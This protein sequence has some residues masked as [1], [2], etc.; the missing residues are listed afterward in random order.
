MPDEQKTHALLEIR[1][2]TVDYPGRPAALSGISFDIHAGEIVGLL[3]ESGGGKTTVG[4][5]VMRVLPADCRVRGSI[6]FRGRDVLGLNER[7][8]QAFRGAEVAMIPQEAGL[9]ANPHL[10]AIHQVEEVVRVHRTL[11]RRQRRHEAR[12]VL[13]DL[14]MGSSR[15]LSAYPNQMSGGEQQRLVA[16]QAMACKPALLIADE[17]SASLDVTLQIHWLEMIRNFRDTAGCAVLLITHNPALLA[18]LA[19]RVV[20]LY[21]GQVVEA[22]PFDALSRAP[23]HPYTSALL[24]AVPSFATGS[25]HCKHLASLPVHTASSGS[26]GVA[27]SFEPRCPD[28]MA[29]CSREKPRLIVHD[30]LQQVR[31]LKYD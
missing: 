29:Q 18:G 17:A 24:R 20:V 1:D 10:R 31:C 7:E 3:G 13:A 21:Q 11:D 12:K 23:L 25:G 22:G 30:K 26:V 2:L 8:L 15:L 5:A 9:A 28:R 19:N 16:A 27:C 14:G 6:R 4:L